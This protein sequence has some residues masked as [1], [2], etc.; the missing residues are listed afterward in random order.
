MDRDASDRLVSDLAV[1]GSITSRPMFGGHGI[2]WNG[3]MFAIV[4]KGRIYLK[5]DDESRGDYLARG[6]EPFRP[7]AR[8]TSRSYWELPPGV[9]DDPEELIA[10]AKDAIRAAQS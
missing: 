9:R 4:F 1:L 10:W 2:Y 6:M 7:N 8:Q 5:V 3:R